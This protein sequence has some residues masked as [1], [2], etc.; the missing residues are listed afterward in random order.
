MPRLPSRR[1]PPIAFAH[2]GGCA[3]HPENTLEAFTAAL[4]SGV[5]GLET[6]AWVTSDG[7]VVLHH[8]RRVGWWPRAPRVRD[9][10]RETLPDHVPTLA[11][12]YE[13]CGDRFELAIDVKDT[14]AFEPILESARAVG[15]AT[16]ERLWLCHPSFDVVAGWRSETD[17]AHL[18]HSTRPSALGCTPERH[19]ARLADAGIDGVNFHHRHWSG[20]LVALYHRFERDAFGWDAQFDRV[21]DELFD[22]GI[23]GVFSD[24]VDRMLSRLAARR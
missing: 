22:A 21:L 20:G 5:T 4:A 2:R 12:L 17:A 8:D 3:T 13:R 1:E 16:E 24:H 6:D 14:A 7:H 18:V 11:D 9:V 19:A 10:R 15:V 23:D